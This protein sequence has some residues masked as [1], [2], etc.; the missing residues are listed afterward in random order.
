[1]RNWHIH[2]LSGPTHATATG[3]PHI[4]T[5]DLLVHNADLEQLVE[6]TLSEILWLCEKEI[7]HFG[8]PNLLGIAHRDVVLTKK[9]VDL[10]RKRYMEILAH[11]DIVLSDLVSNDFLET[12][13][14]LH[15]IS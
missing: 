12:P 4:H 8:Y 9:K 1:M 10:L 15:N 2:H 5:T 11:S 7:G 6:P 3:I 14:K 13:H